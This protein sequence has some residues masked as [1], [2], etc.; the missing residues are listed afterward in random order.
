MRQRYQRWSRRPPRRRRRS[1]QK[2]KW[3]ARWKSG[4][5]RSRERCRRR[6]QRRWSPIR[7]SRNARTRHR[8][9]LRRVWIPPRAGRAIAALATSVSPTWAPSSP[10]RNSTARVTLVRPAT[11]IIT[12]TVITTITMRAVT[13][14]RR[15]A[16]EPKRRCF[17]SGASAEWLLH[18]SFSFPQDL[19]EIFGNT[20]K[21][22]QQ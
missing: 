13:R 11:T 21:S 9:H 12:T 16:V 8:H 1:L 5:V 19:F 3:M 10:T 2:C 4:R 17:K 18:H 22:A 6:R 15:R 20:W 14:R 7:W